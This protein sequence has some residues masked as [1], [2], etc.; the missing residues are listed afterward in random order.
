[1][2]VV[3]NKHFVS[4]GRGIA[5]RLLAITIAVSFFAMLVPV[6]SASWEKSGVMACCIGKEAGHCDSG[7]AGHKPSPPPK[8]EPMCGL[9]SENL[10]AIIVVAEPSTHSHNSRRSAESSSSQAGAETLAGAETEADAESKVSVESAS[11]GRPCPMNCGAC[12]ASTSRFQKRQKDIIQTRTF[13]HSAPRSITR[14]EHLS[15]VFSSDKS[16]THINPRGPPV[17]SL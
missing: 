9:T 17:T 13:H 7:L 2:F 14:F 5:S 12:T 8:P 1:M 16:W 4:A 11:L 10:D 6:A 15:R 3:S